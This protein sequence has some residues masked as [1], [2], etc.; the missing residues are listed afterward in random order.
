V[1]GW[2]VSRSQRDEWASVQGL[3]LVGAREAI[4]TVGLQADQLSG[5]SGQTEGSVEFGEAEVRFDVGLQECSGRATR[6]R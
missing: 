1:A 2:P 6:V 5:L 4:P 3:I